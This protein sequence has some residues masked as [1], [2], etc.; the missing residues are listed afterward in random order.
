[1]LLLDDS[2]CTLNTCR[3]FPNVDISTGVPD[4]AVP[5]KMLMKFRAGLV[6]QEKYKPCV[7]CNTIPQGSGVLHVGD[8]LTVAKTW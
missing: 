3:Q 2:D 4:K 6:P 7:G 1:M 5:Y 8:V